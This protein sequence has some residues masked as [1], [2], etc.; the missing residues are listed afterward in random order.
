MTGSHRQRHVFE[1]STSASGRLTIL[2]LD[3][4]ITTELDSLDEVG[5][6]LATL[7]NDSGTILLLR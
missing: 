7:L 4:F 3:D 1:K 5:K 2:G 6:L